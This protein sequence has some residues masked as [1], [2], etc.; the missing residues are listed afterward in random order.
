MT[1]EHMLTDH[2]NAAT[3]NP[4]IRMETP[5]IHQTIDSKEYERLPYPQRVIQVDIYTVDKPSLTAERVENYRKKLE[6]EIN[7]IYNYDNA[8]YLLRTIASHGQTNNHLKTEAEIEAI[9]KNPELKTSPTPIEK[10][11]Q[12][13]KKISPTN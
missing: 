3:R 13:I 9:L 4:N 12:W 1:A 10:L 6:K 5:D 8:I 2:L 11:V 7:R